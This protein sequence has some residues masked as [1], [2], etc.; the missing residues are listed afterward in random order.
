MIMK[1]RHFVALLLSPCCCRLIV[2]SES[3]LSGCFGFL[4]QILGGGEDL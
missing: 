4:L 3:D 1:A 2:G